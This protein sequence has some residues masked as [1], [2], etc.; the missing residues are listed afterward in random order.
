MVIWLLITYFINYYIKLLKI[1]IKYSFKK[2]FFWNIWL[3]ERPTKP[4]VLSHFMSFAIFDSS[5]S[6][7]HCYYHLTL[8]FIHN[9]IICYFSLSLLAIEFGLLEVTGFFQFKWLEVSIQE[10]IDDGKGLARDIN[11]SK[12]VDWRG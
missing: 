7:F 9:H 6:T 12:Q 3:F 2:R 10:L 8:S 1:N 11:I 5:L 4:P